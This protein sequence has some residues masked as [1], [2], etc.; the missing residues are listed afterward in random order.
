M[1]R[2][3][4]LCLLFICVFSITVYAEET[5][6]IGGPDNTNCAI[7]TIGAEKKETDQRFYADA[8]VIVDEDIT[9]TAFFAG[10]TLNISSKIMHL[11]LVTLFL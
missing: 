4:K 9:K 11:S 7:P 10:N 6:C 3:L 2:F 1:K 8:D 5:N